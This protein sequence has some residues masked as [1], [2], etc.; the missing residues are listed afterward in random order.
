MCVYEYIRFLLWIWESIDLTSV[1][2]KANDFVWNDKA[3]NW[4]FIEWK[5]SAINKQLHHIRA[6][7]SYC[8]LKINLGLLTEL[9]GV[10]FSLKPVKLQWI[11]FIGESFGNIIDPSIVF[12]LNFGVNLH[13]RESKL[14]EADV[15]ESQCNIVP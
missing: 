10:S 12:M 11:L 14:Y 15:I 5:T 8:R 6:E 3:K 2:V 13:M 7:G 1:G 4:V 9:H